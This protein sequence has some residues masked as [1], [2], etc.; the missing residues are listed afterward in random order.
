MFHETDQRSTVRGS[1][2]VANFLVPQKVFVSLDGDLAN[3]PGRRRI[4]GVSEHA[5]RRFDAI[6][7]DEQLHTGVSTF[8]TEA[9][10][11]DE[12]RYAGSVQCDPS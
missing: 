4:S 9:Y 10:T 6:I 8:H 1:G 12:G 7:R 2:P 5:Q 11:D 3:A